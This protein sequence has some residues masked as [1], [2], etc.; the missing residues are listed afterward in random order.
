MDALKTLSLSLVSCTAAKFMS[1]VIQAKRMAG[2]RDGCLQEGVRLKGK[3][4]GDG[5]RSE[6]RFHLIFPPFPTS[7]QLRST[8]GED[9]TR[10]A[11]GNTLNAA[12]RSNY[13][14]R[15]LKR[16]MLHPWIRLHGDCEWI[17]LWS[18]IKESLNFEVGCSMCLHA[19]GVD[20]GSCLHDCSM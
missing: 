3:K 10:P 19:K 2:R 11:G 12:L 14:T 1:S 13:K 17:I 18:L 15:L 8:C 7:A 20:M 6:A 4:R 16:G 5:E 9:G